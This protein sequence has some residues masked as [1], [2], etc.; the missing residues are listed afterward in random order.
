MSSRLRTETTSIE[1]KDLRLG[2]TFVGNDG[3]LHVIEDM[4]IGS[5]FYPG[6]KLSDELGVTHYTGGRAMVRLSDV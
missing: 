3:L 4:Q 2:M 1:A 5:P 6:W